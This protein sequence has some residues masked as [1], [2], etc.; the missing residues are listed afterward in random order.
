MP[1]LD[2]LAGQWRAC[3]LSQ[4]SSKVETLSARLFGKFSVHY[5]RQ[6]LVNLE[7]CKEQELFAYLLLFHH[8]PHSR[9]NLAD[10]HEDY[11]TSRSIKGHDGSQPMVAGSLMGCPANPPLDPLHTTHFVYMWPGKPGIDW[12]HSWLLNLDFHNWELLNCVMVRDKGF[13]FCTEP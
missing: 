11:F 12:G 3:Q 1:W 4:G 6:P 8:R 7:S 13:T 5:G 9:E 2:G 10:L